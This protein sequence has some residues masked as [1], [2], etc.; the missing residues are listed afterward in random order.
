MFRFF[1]FYIKLLILSKLSFAFVSKKMTFLLPTVRSPHS[2][3]ITTVLHWPFIHTS[4]IDPEH[5]IDTVYGKK[6]LNNGKYKFG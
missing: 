2:T 4:T 3:G 1:P 5:R 6:R